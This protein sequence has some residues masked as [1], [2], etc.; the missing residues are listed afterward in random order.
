MRI[1]FEFIDG[2]QEIYD[3]DKITI[4]TDPFAGEHTLEREIDQALM[5]GGIIEVPPPPKCSLIEKI[6]INFHAVKKVT[7]IKDEQRSAKS[8]RR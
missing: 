3:A 7:L 1:R 6:K 8:S 5:R 4:I 2:S